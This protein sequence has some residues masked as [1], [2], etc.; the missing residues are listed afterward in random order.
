[1]DTTHWRRD[2]EAPAPGAPQL[3]RH[4]VTRGVDSFLSSHTGRRWADGPQESKAGSL[5]VAEIQ[6]S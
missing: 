5:A 6:L 1:M 2:L 3:P 4:G